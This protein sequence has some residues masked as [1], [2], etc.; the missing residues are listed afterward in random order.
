MDLA[1]H[2]PARSDQE[3]LA[4]TYLDQRDR[5]TG[6]LATA[7]GNIERLRAAL[8]EIATGRTADGLK[9]DFPRERAREALDGR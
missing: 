8:R 7:R 9:T 4:R 6:E 3:L 5:A 2:P 1:V